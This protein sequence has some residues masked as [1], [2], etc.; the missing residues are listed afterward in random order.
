MQ[1]ALLSYP[2]LLLIFALTLIALGIFLYI[3]RRR[4]DASSG[5]LQHLLES[6][7]TGE[8]LEQSDHLAS[9]LLYE[10]RHP[11]FCGIVALVLKHFPLKRF[12]QRSDFS[13][14]L[15]FLTT[16]PFSDRESEDPI[17]AMVTIVEV[18]LSDL[19]VEY[20]CRHQLRLLVNQFIRETER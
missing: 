2:V 5:E 14:A 20:R 16:K 15:E 3:G 11:A 12:L 1:Q 9:L 4:S 18:F 8:P 10:K 6:A 13:Q 7:R 19:D 17:P